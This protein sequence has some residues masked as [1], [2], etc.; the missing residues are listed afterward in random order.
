MQTNMKSSAVFFTDCTT[1][2]P[3]KRLYGYLSKK[4]YFDYLTYCHQ[5]KNENC[6]NKKQCLTIDNLH[7]QS[8]ELPLL[9]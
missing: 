6:L 4:I 3:L 5:I 1:L 7:P 9:K 2:N 8:F